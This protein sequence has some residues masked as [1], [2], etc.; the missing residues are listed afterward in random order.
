MLAKS[1]QRLICGVH[2]GISRRRI[3]VK[4]P[5]IYRLIGIIG[6]VGLAGSIRIIRIVGL[7][8]SIR[9]VLRIIFCHKL[10]CEIIG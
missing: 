4:R 10:F 7:A 6:F 3:G 1:E 5:G 8:G 9:A 2:D